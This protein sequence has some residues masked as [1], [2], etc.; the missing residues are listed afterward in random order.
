[1]LK[2]KN[3]T[4]F[5]ELKKKKKPLGSQF[6]HTLDTVPQISKNDMFM[7]STCSD[8]DEP[9]MAVQFLQDL[10]KM[11]LTE[12]WG[13]LAVLT[14]KQLLQCYQLLSYDLLYLH[15]VLMLATNR[16]L[17]QRE[18]RHFFDDVLATKDR[19]GK[20]MKSTYSSSP[21]IR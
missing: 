10:L 16:S 5:R 6:Y 9:Q 12:R 21:H 2:L 3:D 7:Y 1:M 14:Q 20:S 15:T 18:R 4:Y 11:Y 8:K 17:D 13:P 19:L